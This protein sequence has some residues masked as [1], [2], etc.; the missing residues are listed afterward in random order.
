MAETSDPKPRVGAA[1]KVLIGTAF[2]A[3]PLMTIVMLI[4]MPLSELQS[5]LNGLWLKFLA[6]GALS[7]NTGMALTSAFLIAATTGV[8]VIAG[9]S[10]GKASRTLSERVG[11][12]L[13]RQLTE[14]AS[15]IP[16]I[17]HF[18]RPE[19]LDKLQLL[20]Q[21]RGTLS[22]LIGTLFYGLAKVGQ[23]VL[24]AILLS[25]IHPLLLLLVLQGVPDLLFAPSQ[26]R[27]WRI[28]EDEV[29]EPQRLATSL[30]KLTSRPE[31][32]KEL[33]IFRLEE[34]LMT[35]HARLLRAAEERLSGILKKVI[36]QSLISTIFS[37]LLISAAIVFVAVQAARGLAT[38][39]DVLLT[40]TIAGNFSNQ[41]FALVSQ[42][43]SSLSYLRLAN[44]F[45]WLMDYAKSFENSDSAEAPQEVR[46]AVR[47]EGVSFKYPGSDSWALEDVSLEFPAGSVV[48]L[49][50][51]NGA[52][53]TTIVKLLSRMYD[54]QEGSITVDGRDLRE[55]DHD[56][57]RHNIAAG[58]QDFMKFEFLARETVGV[59]DLPR[60]ENM[61]AVGAALSRAGAADLPNSF[62]QGLES[63]LG[64]QWDKGIEPSIGQWQK[65]AL[66][67]A[68][69]RDQPLL[70]IL[71]EPTSA[72]DAET[73]HALFERF[74]NAI[75][76]DERARTIT[77]LVS[78]RFS[79]VRMAD[80]IVVLDQG[81]VVE[82]GSHQELMAAGGL[83]AELFELQA[84]GYR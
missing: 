27:A 41:V 69:Q 37:P 22:N 2:R 11:F 23:V 46:D 49:V 55:F 53:K 56:A 80:T 34:D 61:E 45:V 59:G 51:E 5:V 36:F 72:L 73:E 63:Q 31:G 40:A 82:S 4:A 21:Q 64:R 52:G 78:H 16:T 57:W 74:A 32:A 43:R 29:A 66:A 19:Y 10:I 25:S 7:K 13:D 75:R 18:E 8:F 44:R 48:A 83:Y 12:A 14:L 33:R 38:P 71:D 50:G 76:R 62:P 70:L 47:L 1:F 9:L 65:L 17:E 81:R 60:I 15:K 3:A 28:A 20:R 54:P 6:D 67:R 84:R 35:R 26:Q 58:F 30:F 68:L 39:G 79:T 24:P 77:V 42:F